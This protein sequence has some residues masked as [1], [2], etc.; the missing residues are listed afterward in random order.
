MCGTIDFREYLLCALYLI[1]QCLP[2]MDLI[3]IVSKMYVSNLCHFTRTALYNLLRHMTAATVD[4]CVE[5]FT[6]MDVQR[7]GFVTMGEHESSFMEI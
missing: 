2:T 5:Y 6:E 7:N 4:K 1:K 3:Q